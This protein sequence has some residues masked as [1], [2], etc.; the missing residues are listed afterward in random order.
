MPIYEYVCR[1]CGH[2]FELLVRP[3]ITTPACPSC[4]TPDLERRLSGFAVTSEGI[5]QANVRAAKKTLARDPQRLDQRTADQEYTR[6]H[7]AEEGIR[8]PPPS[9]LKK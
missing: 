2:E 4:N 9:D 6:E 8:L 1:A 5:R 3:P 7:M